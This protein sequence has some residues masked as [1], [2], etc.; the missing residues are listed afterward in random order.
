ML[1]MAS[2]RGHTSIMHTIRNSVL[3]AAVAL[4]TTVCAH[5]QPNQATQS[6]FTK[7]MEATLSNDYDAFVA[8]SDATMKA[9]VTKPMLEGVSQQLKPRAD[10][11]YDATYLGEMNKQGHKVHLWRLRFKDGGD[12]ALATLSEKDGKAGGF[13][14]R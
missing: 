14:I 8:A 5:A 4:V 13:Y 10:K 7:L 9:G 11:G 3:G 12:D 6:L 2:N 1:D